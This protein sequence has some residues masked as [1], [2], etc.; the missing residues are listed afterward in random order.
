M[1]IDVTYGMTLREIVAKYG[2]DALD[3]KVVDVAEA[4]QQK[5]RDGL[6][7]VMTLTQF[8]EACYK[9]EVSDT[10]GLKRNTIQQRRQALGLW[11]KLTGDPALKEITR[12]HMQQFVTEVRKEIS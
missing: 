6:S 8:Y 4:K 9:P 12:Q 7:D 1:V 10:K 3:M 5:R 2:M 11:A